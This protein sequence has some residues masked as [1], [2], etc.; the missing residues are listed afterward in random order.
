MQPV[1]LTGEGV[2]VNMPEAKKIRPELAPEADRKSLAGDTPMIADPDPRAL[3]EG[4]H[5]VILHGRTASG[6]HRWTR[7][8]YFNL[9]AA[10][11]AVD[12]AAESGDRAYLVLCR[13]SVVTGGLA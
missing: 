12:R 1:A 7:R 2:A 9:P 10:Q 11:R 4:V 5:V 8:P 13:L 6:G 3:L